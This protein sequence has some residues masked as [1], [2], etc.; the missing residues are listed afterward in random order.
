MVENNRVELEKNIGLFGG[1]SLIINIIVGSG[2][3][4][5]PKGVIQEVGSIGLS[6][7]IWIF[8]GLISIFGALTYT[9]LGCMIPKAGGEYE[10][11]MTAFGNLL[12]FLFVWA[13]LI[14]IIPTANAVAALTFSDYLLQPFFPDCDIPNLARI[15]IAASA[16]LVLTVL[17]C[18]SV[19][20]VNRIQNI[21][22]T[23]KIAALL[24]IIFMGVYCLAIGRYQNFENVMED[25]NY[26][27]GKI[28]VAFY[29]GLFCY[30]GWSYLNYVV[31]EVK[32]PTKTLPRAIWLGLVIVIIVYSFTN[33]AYFT[34]LTPKEMI[35]SSAVAV[36]FVEKLIG[37]YSWIMSILVALSTFGFINSILLSTSRI[38]FG[39]ARNNHMP[40][41]L[42]FINIKF[43]TPMVSVIFMSVAT[44]ICLNIKNTYVLI[45]MGVLAEYIFITGAVCG[46]LYLRK[47]QPDISRPIKVNLFYPITFLIVCFFII[48]MTLYQIPVE[49][50]M[51]IAV[52]ALGIPVY[53]LGVKWKKP[54][55]IQKKLDA[56]TIF[57]QKLTYSVFD[58]SKLE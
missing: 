18:V 39:A 51:C 38:I 17:N 29:S 48:L 58:E 35:D 42:A 54:D 12:G 22:S 15:F 55:S 52:L 6:I 26:D 31:E 24:M 14:I 10:Y 21:F 19:K 34:L 46:L 28:A 8:C 3:F 11:L 33:V 50:F 25:S 57:V 16:V 53:F 2:I 43:L 9:E 13:Q 49:S 27:A 45:N 56:M 36:S 37:E 44:L 1:V 30:T 5:S 7:A 23:G 41:I 32:E 47:S 4:V 20:W 40:T